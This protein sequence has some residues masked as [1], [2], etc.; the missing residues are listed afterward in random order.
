MS[1]VRSLRIRLGR[2]EVGSLFGLD[3]GRVYFRFDDAY[4]KNP[5][6]PVQSQLYVVAPATEGSAERVAQAVAEAEAATVAQLLDPALDANRGDGSFGLPPFFQNL[7]PEG[8]LR[9]QLIGDLGLEVNDELGLLAACGGDLPGDV[10]A[11]AE[12]LED[13]ALGRLIGQS[14]DSY[15]MSSGQVP[16]P[17]QTSIS[18]VQPK[19]ALVQGAAG[20]YVMR[21]R[22]SGGRHFIGKLPTAEYD[23]LPEVEYSALRLAAAAGVNTCDASLQPLSAI[24]DQLPY[25]LQK[26]ERNFLL[27]S[28]FDRDVDTETRRLHM[29]D[30]AQVTGTPSEYKYSG[31]YAAIG[32]LLKRRSA[33]GE[34]DVA[35]LL[36]RIKVSE[37]LGNYDAHLKNFS[38]VYL[39]GQ[40]RPEL[41]KAYDIVAYGVYFKGSGHG[42]Q[43]FPGQKPRTLL[44]PATLRQLANAWDIPE[45]QLR[46]VV[47]DCIDRAM[48]SWPGLLKTLPLSPA[49]R[50]RLAAYIESNAS[51]SSWRKRHPGAEWFQDD[52]SATPAA[53][54]PPP[55][56]AA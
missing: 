16:T 38:L 44:T 54:P 31:T 49:H 43:F 11:D 26:D 35:E 30:F 53:G 18:G 6:R 19:V 25:A 21:S 1:V 5:S 34:A 48:R 46:E 17:Q 23:R 56:G 28:R 32:L 3:D 51:V 52:L 24:A 2:T 40:A 33:R 29:E 9:K 50:A 14:R 42:L 4:A 20:R 8:P 27:V 12:T 22:R 39:P 45:K 36:R 10:W 41:S 7:L 13:S 15:E 37:L 55:A 47:A